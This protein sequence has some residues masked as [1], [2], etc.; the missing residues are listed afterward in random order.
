MHPNRTRLPVLV[1]ALASL[2]QGCRGRAEE[3][4]PSGTRVK[5]RFVYVT[6]MEPSSLDPFMIGDE[7]PAISTLMNVYQTL[8]RIDVRGTAFEP[9]LA[10]SWKASDDGLTWTFQLRRD[11]RFSNGKQVTSRDV[12]FS[13]K[14]SRDIPG[15]QQKYMADVAGIEARGDHM[16]VITLKQRSAPFLATLSL[17]SNAILSADFFESASPEKLSNQTMGSGPYMI[18]EWKKGEH[19]LL[20]ANPYYHE[21]GLPKTREVQLLYIKDENT[22][23]IKLQTGAVDGIDGPQDARLAEMRDDPSLQVQFGSLTVVAFLLLNNRS[24][25]LANRDFRKAL[26]YAIDREGLV[27]ALTFG[28]STPATSFLTPNTLYFDKDLKGYGYDLDKAREHLARSGV[29][30]G[31]KLE[32]LT[33]MDNNPFV[34]AVKGMWGK[35][36]LD[37]QLEVREIAT[38]FARVKAGDFQIWDS[39]WNND[40]PDPSQ[41]SYYQLHYP[42]MGTYNSG[43]RSDRMNALIE[44]GA[45]EL[46]P[47]KRATIYKDIQALAIEDSP[48]IW[49]AYWTARATLRK[50]VEGYAQSPIGWMFKRVVVRQ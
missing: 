16:V 10:E 2:A 27:K 11:A 28:N 1:L 32:I 33:S 39:G 22:S 31:T 29:P 18:V 37:V 21:A 48:N 3:S 6:P 45:R 26:A 14:R 34:V 23:I 44:A 30:A 38:V 7:G 20:R 46:D 25:P 9:D 24:G 41:A 19:L 15:S 8:V 36:G 4:A 40:I 5:D 13:L 43:Y 12:V 49:V 35:L 47:V 42:Q 17:V 50:N